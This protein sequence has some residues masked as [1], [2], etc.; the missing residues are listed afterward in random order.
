M[1]GTPKQRQKA[2]EEDADIYVL[3]RDSVCWLEEYLGKK[4][5]FDC[6]VIDEFSS[7]KNPK[8]KRFKALKRLRQKGYIKRLIGLTGT[9]C[10]NGLMDLWS[11]IYLL[12]A[13]RRLGRTLTA[14]REKYFY[15]GA[16]NG[17]IVFNWIPQ[18][19]ALEDITKSI[20]DICLSMKAEDYLDMPPII[21][22]NIEVKLPKSAIK[23]Y[24]EL[25]REY[26]TELNGELLFAQSSAAAQSKICQLCNGCVY[27]EYHDIY[28]I[29]D[30]KIDR[31]EE[32][33][34]ANAG[35]SMLIF[36]S[37][38][39]DIPRIQYLLTKLKLKWCMIKEEDSI[40][41]WN[42]KE[43]DV[44]LAHPAST[45]YGLNLQFGGH[46]ILWFGAPDNLEWYQQANARLYRQGQTETVI[47]NHLLIENSL[48]QKVMKS[49][50]NKDDIQQSVT[51]AVKEYIEEVNDES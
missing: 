40:D 9:P 10:P 15:P 4:W 27:N 39:H 33:L 3:S 7:F 50:Q 18:D 11:Q 31:L 8:A 30:A 47:I 45:C 46:N 19:T 20:S 13:G 14:Y 2:L 23:H 12:D 25:E 17:H 37:F 42:N 35:K 36:Y 51:D 38:Q 44:L 29:H 5:F 1:L 48:E 43:L 28:H 32:L 24:K 34:E 49:L 16:R 22:N 26:V 6:V 21:Y 41:R